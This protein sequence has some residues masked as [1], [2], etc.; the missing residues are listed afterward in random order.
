MISF[1]AT[2][3]TLH[4]G[5]GASPVSR[6]AVSLREEALAVAAQTATRENSREAS[7]PVA[8]IEAPFSAGATPRALTRDD[9]LHILT[10]VLSNDRLANAA[11]WVAN[12]PVS[13][14]LSAEKVFVSIRI[15]TP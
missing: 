1:L 3:F 15:S 5:L 4:L 11:M 12:Q 14:N 7:Q 9:W 13:L 8:T 6:A 2:I 10:D